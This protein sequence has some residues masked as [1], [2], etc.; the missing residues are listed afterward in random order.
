MKGTAAMA[1]IGFWV[2]LCTAAILSHLAILSS[3]HEK[4]GLRLRGGLGPS[5]GM[6][7]SKAT[8][9]HQVELNVSVSVHHIR[10]INAPKTRVVMVGNLPELGD[11]DP[12][13][14]VN[15]ET[16]A[17][18]FP[19]FTGQVVLPPKT[20]FEYKYVIVAE[21]GETDMKQQWE[22]VNRPFTT[23]ASATTVIRNEFNEF[24]GTDPRL[25]D[26]PFQLTA[27]EWSRWFKHH[28]SKMVSFP[29]NYS[30]HMQTTESHTVEL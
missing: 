9:T 16:N 13:R 25:T 30:A 7:S 24:R 28:Q 20:S 26:E 14:G 3:N 5:E 29:G 17:V 23:D 15:L 18:T 1:A 4:A 27:Q 12:S 2:G 11:W 22:A 8:A 6:A 19:I 21:D 10:S